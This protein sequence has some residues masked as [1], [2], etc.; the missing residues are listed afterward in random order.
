MSEGERELRFQDALAKLKWWSEIIGLFSTWAII[1]GIMFVSLRTI[2]RLPQPDAPSYNFAFQM[3]HKFTFLAITSLFV[4]YSLRA[5]WLVYCWVSKL[6]SEKGGWLIKGTDYIFTA[7][8]VSAL[9]MGM[10]SMATTIA[11]M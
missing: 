7:V 4:I 6:H 3:A 5:A 2:D 1:I 9:V 8:I 10:L 11:Q